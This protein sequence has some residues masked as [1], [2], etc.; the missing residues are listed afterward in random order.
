MRGFPGRV[1]I[2]SGSD[3]DQVSED[4][5]PAPPTPVGNLIDCVLRQ[6]TAEMSGDTAV[7]VVQI[8]TAAYSSARSGK[9]VVLD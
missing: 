6:A 2:K 4:D 7:Q 5:L 8:V 9:R 3:H 1:S